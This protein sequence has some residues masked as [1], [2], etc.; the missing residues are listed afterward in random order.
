MFT[1]VTALGL[2]D[3]SRSHVYLVVL[4]E[5]MNSIRRKAKSYLST[6]PLYLLQYVTH[7]CLKTFVKKRTVIFIDGGSQ[8]LRTLSKLLDFWLGMDLLFVG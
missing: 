3:L 5:A 4:A 2:L 1:L 6:F 7:R 8:H